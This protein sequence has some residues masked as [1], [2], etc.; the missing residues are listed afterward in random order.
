MQLNGFTVSM[1][2]KPSFIKSQVI[3]PTIN[4]VRVRV[5]SEL[6]HPFHQPGQ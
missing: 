4:E 3:H 6:E 1:A 5:F 2:E